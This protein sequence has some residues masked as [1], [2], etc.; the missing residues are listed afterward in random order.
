MKNKT[1]D[2]IINKSGRFL[3]WIYNSKNVSLEHINIRVLDE[4]DKLIEWG[5]KDTIFEVLELI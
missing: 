4:A 2:I 3:D 5:F 1:P